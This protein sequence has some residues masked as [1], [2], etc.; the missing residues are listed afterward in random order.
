MNT[1]LEEDS[2]PYSRRGKAVRQDYGGTEG[3]TAG[4][5]G[6]GLYPANLKVQVN[7]A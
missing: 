7:V 2:T 5:R 3:G 4:V 6:L 1:S